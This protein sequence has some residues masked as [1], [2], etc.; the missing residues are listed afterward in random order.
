MK[1]ARKKTKRLFAVNC[2]VLMGALFIFI[3]A[4]VVIF[5]AGTHSVKNKAETGTANGQKINL[6]ITGFDSDGV[7]TDLIL[8]A[9]FDTAKMSAEVLLIPENTR[10]YVGGRYQKISAAHAISENGKQKGVGGTVDAINRLTGIPL[11]YYAEFST[12]D[13]AALIDAVGG[14]EFDVERDMKYQ[15]PVQN[16]KIDLKKGYQTLTGKEACDLLRFVSYDDGEEERSALQAEF[17]AEFVTQKL[18]PKYIG[19]LA[20][21]FGKLDISTNL[22]ADDV[23]KYANLLLSVKS[24]DITIHLCPGKSEKENVRYWIPDMEALGRLVRDVFDNDAEN[25]AER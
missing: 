6:L 11:N 5:L 21:L 20:E 14:I 17:F 7:R 10:M 8:V 4:F 24:G 15:D 22:T 13:F 23:I 16:L 2:K 9:S 25:T 18:K 12:E 3:A 19:S 1:R